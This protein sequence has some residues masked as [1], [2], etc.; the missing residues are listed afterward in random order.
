MSMVVEEACQSVVG[1][2]FRSDHSVLAV[3]FRD[4]A[5]SL[6]YS[7][8]EHSP[9]SV[10]LVLKTRALILAVKIVRAKK[11]VLYDV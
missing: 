11:L 9:T 5:G 3:S 1:P 4:H 2:R 8:T 6:C 7:Y 10:A